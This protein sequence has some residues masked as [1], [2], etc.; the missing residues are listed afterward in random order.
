MYVK[1]TV[2]HW[3]VMSRED[4]HFRLRI[5]EALKKKIE[6]AADANRRS[7][8][9]EIVSRLER[10]DSLGGEADVAIEV[11]RAIASEV[12][13]LA[14][15]TLMKTPLTDQIG[16]AL[17]EVGEDGSIDQAKI[18]AHFTSQL[19]QQLQ[20]FSTVES[21]APG[22]A[23]RVKVA[24]A[25]RGRSMHEEIVQTLERAFPPP[26]PLDERLGDLLITLG[27]LAAQVQDETPESILADFTAK[28]I[29]TLDSINRGV[30][31]TDERTRSI[32]A[33]ALSK[34]RP[35]SGK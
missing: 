22:L 25:A 14:D 27:T 7:M 17:A 3:C 28:L 23:A 8:T 11:A 26:P 15:P 16:D 30:W 2:C 33:E 21:L 20:P 24:A 29:D 35:E 13:R 4:Q 18:T 19:R 12:D 34:I 6:A 5:P 32:A 1:P 9:A 31:T 10:Y